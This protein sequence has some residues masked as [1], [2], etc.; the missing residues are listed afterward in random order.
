MPPKNRRKGH[1]VRGIERAFLI[2]NRPLS[3]AELREWA[4]A[5]RL[6]QG[7]NS[8]REMHYYCRNLRRVC[9]L[10][11]IRVGRSETGSGRAILWRLR[12]EG[13]S[14]THD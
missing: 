8:R 10:M 7:R 5:L 6:Y 9:E 1:I 3:T 13:V 14:G 11:C 2:D 4:Y 12:A